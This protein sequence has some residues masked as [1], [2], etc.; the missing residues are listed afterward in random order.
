MTP[1]EASSLPDIM[2]AALEVAC[3]GDWRRVVADG[4]GG[5][6]VR[7]RPVAAKKA[8]APRRARRVDPPAPLVEVGGQVFDLDV[9]DPVP[10]PATAPRPCGRCGVVGHYVEDCPKPVVQRKAPRQRSMKSIALEDL[11][12]AFAA[13]PAQRQQGGVTVLRADRD[14]SYLRD[15]EEY[16]EADPSSPGFDWSAVSAGVEGSAHQL[17]QRFSRGYAGHFTWLPDVLALEGMDLGIVEDALRHAERVE[18]RP[19]SKPKGYPILGFHRGD[20]LTV[21]GFKNPEKPCVIAAY[22]S[23]RLE[24]DTHRVEHHGGGAGGKA[25][26]G[27]PKTPTQLLSRLRSMGC[28]TEPDAAHQRAVVTY[29]GHDLGKVSIAQG[30]TRQQVETDYQRC[31]RRVLGVQ[32]A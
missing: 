4:A 28:K 24:H 9:V 26:K 19:E 27:L 15:R 6:I 16:V 8:P 32:R 2:R 13:A 1:D 23:S 7:N 18:V 12:S 3:D 11:A 5:Y 10:V 21:L 22:V 29:D 20:V 30:T 14:R 17:C 31:V 25:E